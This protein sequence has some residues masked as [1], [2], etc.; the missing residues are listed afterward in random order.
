MA[1]E[2]R[3]IKTPVAV[4]TGGASG[5]GLAC[6]WRLG[7]SHQLVLVDNNHDTLESATAA[8]RSAGFAVTPKE[9]DVTVATALAGLADEVRALGRLAVLVNAAGLSPTMAGGRRIMQVNLVGTALVERAFLPLV[10]AGTAAVLIAS[11]A[12]HMSAAAQAHEAALSRP[13]DPDL[14]SKLGADG[15]SPEIAYSLSKR[16][17]MLYCEAV[18]PDWAKRGG[19]VVSVSPGMIETPM[20][21]LEFSKQPLMKPM[22]DMTPLGRWGQADDIAAA[23]EFLVSP[24]AS[25]ITGTDLRVDG[26]I[27]PLFKHMVA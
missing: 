4:I 22:L 7:R 20:G 8:L 23:V 25:F 19:R 2:S 10:E 15:E 5:I 12:G 18:A 27:T 21:K 1:D 14:L 11:N 6:A 13:L 17:V 24:Q 9:I 16:G 3:S 26:G